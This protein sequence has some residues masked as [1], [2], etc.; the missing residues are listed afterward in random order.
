MR[1][2]GFIGYIISYFDLKCKVNC[3]V[4]DVIILIIIFLLS[5]DL[6]MGWEMVFEGWGSVV[7]VM[8]GDLLKVWISLRLCKKLLLLMGLSLFVVCGLM[9]CRMLNWEGYGSFDMFEY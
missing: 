1:G 4:S 8:V 3:V 6:L 5:R 2:S 7:L 9:G